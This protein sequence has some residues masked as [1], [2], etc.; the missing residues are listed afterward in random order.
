METFKN[1][2]E[3]GLYIYKGDLGNK[4]RECK[5]RAKF[6]I[7]TGEIIITKECSINTFDNHNYVKEKIIKDKFKNNQINSENIREHLY[8]KIYFTE[9][10]LQYPNLTYNEILLNMIEKYEV[11]KITF[12]PNQFNVFK[13]NYN[14]KNII[15]NYH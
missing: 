11:G 4:D 6:I 1:E 7:K 2:L 10:Y 14:K 9:T 13:S 15:I 5:G 12:T 3:E 8:Q